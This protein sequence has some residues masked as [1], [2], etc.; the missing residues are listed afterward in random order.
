MKLQLI[1]LDDSIKYAFHE[2]WAISPDGRR[3]AGTNGLTRALF[4]G[5]AGNLAA[6]PPQPVLHNL[7]YR[8]SGIANGGRRDRPDSFSVRG[9]NDHGDCVG[10]YDAAGTRRPFIALAA[11]AGGRAHA[12]LIP[13]A[14]ACP[15]N[16]IEY[17]CLGINNDRTVIGVYRPLRGPMVG[18]V[19]DASQ[20]LQPAIRTLKIPVRSIAKGGHRKTWAR[21]IN[22]PGD[23]VGSYEEDGIQHGWVLLATETTFLRFQYR[24]PA[25][26]SVSRPKESSFSSIN[27]H[28]ILVGRV[29]NDGLSA[30]VSLDDNGHP[31]ID[32]SSIRVCSFKLRERTVV[33]GI[34]TSGNVTGYSEDPRALRTR[35]GYV[36]VPTWRRP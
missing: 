20:S 16:A 2:A 36:G 9:V 35:R 6:A 32:R 10:F 13:G 7:A 25:Q 19:A 1:V 15:T 8:L 30:R 4:T 33:T 5:M 24:D 31:T 21:G 27:D 26:T 12:L 14:Q 23:I 3:V 17:A 18:F 11:M 22:S 34:D 29:G 28:G